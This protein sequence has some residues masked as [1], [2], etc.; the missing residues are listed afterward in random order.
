MT[1][2]PRTETRT[3]VCAQCQSQISISIAVGE[4]RWSDAEW[5]HAEPQEATR[6]RAIPEVR[7]ACDATCPNCKYPEIGFAPARDEFVCSRCGHTQ[8]ERPKD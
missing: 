3:S 4:Q 5:E 7:I 1:T 8:T 2:Q 6:H